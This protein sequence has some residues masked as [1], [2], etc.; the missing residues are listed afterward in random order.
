M[1][2]K[3]QILMILAMTTWGGAWVCG[4]A[5]SHDLNFQELA[6]VRFL[7]AFLFSVP[8]V[9]LFRK[10]LRIDNE[11]IKKII[12]GSLFYT[13][14]S[15]FFFLGVARGSAGLGGLL[16]HTLIPIIT[17]S[18]TMFLSRIRIH[19][20][21]ASGLIMGFAG[22]LIILRIWSIDLEQLLR[23]GNLFFL[24]SAFLWS[25][26]TI[27]SEKAQEKVSIWVFSFYLNGFSAILQFLFA[28]PIGIGDLFP[29]TISFWAYMIYLSLFSSVLATAVYFYAAKLL[30]PHKASVFTFLVPTSTI[31]LSWIFLKEIPETSTLI[32]GC[33]SITAVYLVQYTKKPMA[34]VAVIS[35]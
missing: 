27:N 21:E 15:Q 32:G 13:V 5:V 17:F 9:L 18:A 30:G 11:T 3:N 4:K 22:T 31:I 20:L 12:I 25:G 14:Y 33:I 19:L 29:V 26:L 8:P 24:I 23:T 7:L 16:V 2:V 10:S 6:F 35:E 1:R 28:A 34:N